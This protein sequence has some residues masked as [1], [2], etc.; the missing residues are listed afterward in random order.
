MLE[1]MKNQSLFTDIGIKNTSRKELPFQTF[2]Q[3][4]TEFMK[5]VQ[6]GI[7]LPSEV[8]E[9]FYEAVK[10]ITFTH[11]LRGDFIDDETCEDLTQKSALNIYLKIKEGKFLLR[12]D[13]S[14]VAY[15][16][17]VV[18]NS[19]IDYLRSKKEGYSLDDLEESLVSSYDN[20]TEKNR[21]PIELKS[22]LL[23]LIENTQ[24]PEDLFIIKEDIKILKNLSSIQRTILEMR[25]AG[26]E[27]SE[28]GKL[29]NKSIVNVKQ[30]AFRAR[31]LLKNVYEENYSKPLESI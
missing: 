28:I 2:E 3:P 7:E 10:F 31:K 8:G 9:R 11:R 30:I 29:L 22:E 15:I 21:L 18:K 27:D 20:N 13:I 25:A 4:V 26:Y 16:N 14:P 5:Y 19:Y 23:G 17:R 12:K 24:S 6:N 1:L